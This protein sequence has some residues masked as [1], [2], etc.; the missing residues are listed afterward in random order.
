[1]QNNQKIIGI[2]GAG[3]FLGKHLM[4][5][6]T[7][8]DY[9][10]KVATRNPYLKGYLKPLGNPGQIELFK[11]NIF[12]PEDV[13]QV[14]KNCD[15]AIN[16][17]GILYETRKQK[18]NQIHAQFPNLLSELCNE[19]GIKKLVHVS[20]LGV[21]EGHPSQ[22]MQSKLQGEKNIQDTFKQSV[23]LRPGI[24]FGPED[25]FFNTFATLAQFSP[26]LP[27]IGGGKTVFEPIYVGDVAQTIVKSLELNNSKS[28][29]YE[30]GGANYSFKELMQILLSE[31]NKKRFLIPIPWGMA[32]FQSYFLQMLPTPLLTPDQVTMLRYDNV[33]S[34]EYKT[35]KNL[36]IQPTTIQSILPKYIYRFRSGGEFS[37]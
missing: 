37:K 26:A 6:L 13:K 28:S 33:V 19:L 20:A 11:T 25:K 36:K 30:L 18:F 8:L 35:L 21:K 22:Y 7:K 17:V 1:M 12:N 27:L 16:L 31:I 3:G 2:F 24:M 14:L 5:Q 15:L 4:R 10:V 23:I 29:I 34:G 9:R 32:K